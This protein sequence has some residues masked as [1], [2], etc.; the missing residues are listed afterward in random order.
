MGRRMVITI[1]LISILV[2]SACSTQGDHQLSSTEQAQVQGYSEPM[3]DNLLSALKNNDYQSFSKNFDPTLR[4]ILN[5]AAFTDLLNKVNSKIG[6]CSSRTIGDMAQSKGMI[7]V[8]Y[9]LNC[10]NN[11]TVP[12]QVSFKPAEPHDILAF[13][14]PNQ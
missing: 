6:N 1:A 8:N 12:M 2:L 14:F 9:T 11:R 10:D 5:L 4:A 13:T 3:V 7:V